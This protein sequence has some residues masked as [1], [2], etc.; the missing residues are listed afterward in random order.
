MGDIEASLREYREVCHTNPSY[1][2]ARL[3]LGVTLYT[4][5][6]TEEAVAEWRAVLEIDPQNKNA[7][8]YL[9]MVGAVAP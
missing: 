6:R 3:H 8:A 5:R 1:V 4:A 2:P 9:K 7:H